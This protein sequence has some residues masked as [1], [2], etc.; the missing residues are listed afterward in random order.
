MELFVKYDH[1]T[2]QVTAGPQA[3]MSGVS[4]WYSYIAENPEIMPTHVTGDRFIESLGVVMPVRLGALP[5]PNYAQL[6]SGA[7]PKLREQ[8]DLLF[9]D[10]TTGNLTT[11]GGFYSAL[12]AVKSEFP[13]DS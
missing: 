8:L 3:G 4:G 7:Y 11:S 2:E 9:H 10:L 13:K 12:A 5:D 6:R 1:E